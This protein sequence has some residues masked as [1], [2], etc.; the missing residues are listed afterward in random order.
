[1]N[2]LDFLETARDFPATSSARRPRQTNLRRAVSTTYY[3]LFHCLAKCSAD[4]VVGDGAARSVTDGPFEAPGELV[5]GFWIWR[6]GD[7]D[8]AVAWVK[9]CPTP[10]PAP[11]RSR[12]GRCSRRRDFGDA[13][14][15][16]VAE[17]EAR[18]R[19]KAAGG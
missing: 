14:T 2:P 7:M 19:D 1:M 13:M 12:S 6:V 9:R 18:I 8:E 17:Q 15:P 5:A 11:A 3:A 4:M 10:C 16:E